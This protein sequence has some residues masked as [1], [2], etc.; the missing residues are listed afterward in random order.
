LTGNGA[1]PSTS[2]LKG[3]RV[4]VVDDEED[5]RDL[6]VAVLTRCGAEVISAA[7]VPA[8]LAELEQWNPDLLISDIGLPGEDG[9][10]LIRKVRARKSPQH[11]NVPAIA[12]TA[13]ASVEDRLRALSAGFQMHVT[14]PLE[15]SDLVTAVAN[16]AGRKAQV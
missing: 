2:L 10:S 14:K 12:L 1:V 13:Y 16:L 8:A 9:Y 3:L 4:L 6:I 5:S 7:S 11:S 15:P